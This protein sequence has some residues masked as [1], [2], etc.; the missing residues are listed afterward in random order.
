MHGAEPLAWQGK[1][2]LCAVLGREA[3]PA[4]EHWLWKAFFQSGT[5]ELYFLGREGA[6]GHFLWRFPSSKLP[7]T[8]PQKA[9]VSQGQ[10]Q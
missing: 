4:R 10:K 5:T 2:L 7:T 8:E 3:S 1:G 9:L 6:R